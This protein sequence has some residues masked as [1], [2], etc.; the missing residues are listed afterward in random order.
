MMGND[1]LPAVCVGATADSSICAPARGTQLVDMINEEG[2]EV[3]GRRR[4]KKPRKPAAK[5]ASWDNVDP[6]APTAESPVEGGRLQPIAAKVLMKI[7]YGARMARFDL[8]RAVCHLA[9]HITRWSSD[10][11]RRLHRLICYIHSSYK[12]R[13]VGWIGDKPSE[14]K[15]H[16][17]A[18]ADFAGCTA[19]QRSTSGAHL[20]VRGP[21][22]CFPIA[23]LSN[24]QGCVSV[25]TPE[26]E[27]VAMMTALKKM[28]LPSLILWETLLN[29]HV[30]TQVHEDNAAM[31]RVCETGKNPTM[32]YLSRTHGISVAFLH[33]RFKSKAFR[34]QYQETARM[35]ADIYTKAFNDPLKWEAACWLINVCSPEQLVA[36]G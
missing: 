35:A 33:E 21:N 36:D 31:I 20:C 12:H 7:L 34:L 16:L 13:M 22:S 25:S 18:D 2:E 26:A 19:T 15:P 23:A 4:F 28:G 10:C 9:C 1:D 17:Y 8:L 29:P 14:L 11:D 5:K 6:N 30:V 24:R 3:Q 32:R 27:I